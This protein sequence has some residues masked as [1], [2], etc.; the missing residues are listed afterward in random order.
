[1]NSFRK[2]L[3]AANP[4]PTAENAQEVVV[5]LQPNSYVQY[6]YLAYYAYYA[7]DIRNGDIL[8][9]VG[10]KE[11]RDLAGLFRRIW[12]QGQAGVDVPMTIYRDGETMD[13]RIKSSERGRFL[14][15]PS[16]H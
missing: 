5:Q 9:S 10:G 13:L 7:K 4:H 8:L 2:A 12:A 15:G 1:M 16:L 3:L 14:K 6:E 11:V